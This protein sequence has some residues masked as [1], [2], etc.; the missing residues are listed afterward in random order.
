MDRTSV[1]GTDDV[2]SIPTGPTRLFIPQVA[3]YQCLRFL[4]DWNRKTSERRLITPPHRLAAMF[5]LCRLFRTTSCRP[6][7]NIN[8]RTFPAHLK[9]G[10]FLRHEKAGHVHSLKL[11]KPDFRGNSAAGRKGS[12]H[13]L[14]SGPGS[15]WRSRASVN[16]GYLQIF[17]CLWNITI[18]FHQNII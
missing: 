16:K 18:F 14:G 7:G 6:P 13:P 3:V 17:V 1:S 4:F 15:R 5:R 11:Q 9:G 2:G 10:P 12:G 8:R